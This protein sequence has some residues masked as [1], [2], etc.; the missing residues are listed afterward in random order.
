MHLDPFL[1]YLKKSKKLKILF[2]GPLLPPI[3][4][5]SL[6]FTRFY[7]S[8]EDKNKIVI[9]TNF[10]DKT[11]IYKI[12]LTF[13]TIFLIVFKCIF[14]KYNVIY[15]TCSRSFFGSIKDIV[16]I[17]LGSLKS[18]KLINH[19]H[20]SDFYDFF[21]SVPE[22]YKNILC[23]SYAK[24]STSIVLLDSM[25]NQFRDFTDMKLVVVPNFYDDELNKELEKKDAN[26]INLL[27]LSNI[28]KSKGIF[29][30]IDAFEK[31]SLRNESLFLNIAGDF[32]ADEYMSIE[33]VKEEFYGK[34]A[35]NKKINYI[36]KVFGQ[37]KIKLLQK[38][39][40]FVLPT[41]YKSEAFPISII[42]AMRCGNVIVTTNYKYLPE[43]VKSK[44]GILVK[45]KSVDSLVDGIEILLNNSQ[46][47]RK[48]QEHNKQE[49]KEEYSLRQYIENLNKI[50]MENRI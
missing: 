23:L 49:A 18:I 28:M 17:N 35:K 15:F 20:G 9:N 26:V 47:L 44:N 8:V 38:S 39:D 31:L 42:E 37:N 22:F 32:I 5:Q 30:L 2:V 4:G 27:Y 25:K 43:I 7:E 3:H 14:F 48:I 45:S 40:I 36:G 19:L 21:H 6:A 50:I 1:C 10:E 34:L 16:L 12:L 24:V 41:Y 33:K 46:R 11:K 13:K 29:E